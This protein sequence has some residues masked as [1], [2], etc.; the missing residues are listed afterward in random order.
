MKTKAYYSLLSREDDASPWT[1]EFGD[2]DKE[3]VESEKEEYRDKGV[4]A[5]NLKIIRTD[6]SQAAINAKVAQLN[7]K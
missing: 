5:T 3:C 7:S 6:D 2:Y 1:I 4:K